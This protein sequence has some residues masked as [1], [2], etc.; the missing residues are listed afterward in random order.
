VRLTCDKLNVNAKLLGNK[1]ADMLMEKHSLKGG[2][3]LSGV[4]LPMFMI[5]PPDSV[6]ALHSVQI[7][8]PVSVTL[9]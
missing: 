2:G 5:K 9:I 8:A 7:N 6:R 3:C 4:E 1:S